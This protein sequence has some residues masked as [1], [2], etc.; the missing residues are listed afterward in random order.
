MPQ[1]VVELQ[2][3]GSITVNASDPQAA[4]ENATQGGNTPV[5][6]ANLTAPSPNALTSS[7]D[8]TAPS[9]QGGPSAPGNNT[10]YTNLDQYNQEYANAE[11]AANTAYLQA[12]M[13]NET[14]DLAFRKA[15]Q[16]FSESLSRANLLGMFEGQPTMASAALT[17]MWQGSPT[18]Q[19][20]GQYFNQALAYQTQQQKTVQ[21][22]L[23]LL[24]SL[25]G[26]QDYGQYLRVMAS[27]PEGLRGLVNAAAGNQGRVPGF[28]VTGVPPQGVTLPGFMAAAGGGTAAPGQAPTGGTSYDEYMKAA[29]NLPPPSQIAPQNWNAMTDSQRKLLLGMYEQTGWNMTD[30]LQQYQA[31]LPKFGSQT[32]QAGQVRLI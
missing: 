2:G 21:D 25:R 27:S 17:G 6:S 24:S 5:G 26:P 29:Q 3:G 10:T 19:A 18:L 1:Y 28:G 4:M 11:R 16:A 20:Q 15:Q 9:A 32:P 14:D 22:Y 31:S 30:A 13:R 23:T 12:K 7:I 8:Y